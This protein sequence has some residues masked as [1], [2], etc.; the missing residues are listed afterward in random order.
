MT[1]SA[2]LTYRKSPCLLARFTAGLSIICRYGAGLVKF[3]RGWVG[4]FLRAG[5]RLGQCWH[6]LGVAPCTACLAAFCLRES[7]LGISGH[8]SPANGESRAYVIASQCIER[9][10][11]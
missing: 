1:K 5:A 9:V 3:L 8:S 10:T 7:L 4:P 2:S 11:F 6:V